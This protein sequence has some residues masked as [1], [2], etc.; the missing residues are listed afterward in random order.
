MRDGRSIDD[1]AGFIEV[2]IDLD[3]KFYERK[4]KRN[5][6]SGKRY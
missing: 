1:L 3:D 2:V 6:K 4:I 5:L